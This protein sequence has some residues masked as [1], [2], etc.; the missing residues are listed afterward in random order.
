MIE[1]KAKLKSYIE[2]EEY[3]KAAVIRDKI[4]KLEK[5]EIKEE[6]YGKLE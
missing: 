6:N 3:E 5:A 4:L 2:Q 1:L